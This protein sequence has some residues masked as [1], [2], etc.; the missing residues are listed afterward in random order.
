MV[1]TGFGCNTL[2][3][4]FIGICHYGRGNV[5]A[6]SN[7][8]DFNSFAFFFNFRLYL[9][10]DEKHLKKQQNANSSPL[11]LFQRSWVSFWGAW[12]LVLGSLGVIFR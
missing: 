6:I 3:G 9:K 10:N 11:T 5:S 12:T 1:V 4:W 7:L 2:S 8:F